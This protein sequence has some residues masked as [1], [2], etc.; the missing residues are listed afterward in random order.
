MPVRNT[1][2]VPCR[3]IV[4]G[5]GGAMAPL[6]TNLL[7]CFAVMMMDFEL[8]VFRALRQQLCGEAFL[9]FAPPGLAIPSMNPL[10]VVGVLLLCWS[11]VREVKRALQ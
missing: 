7:L 11:H 2:V 9:I 1:F 8:P 3:G 10:F 4:Y 6:L 5:G